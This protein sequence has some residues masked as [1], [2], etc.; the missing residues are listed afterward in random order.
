M[1]GML[2]IDDESAITE[3]LTYH[4]TQE[5]WEVAAA[6]SGESGIALAEKTVPAIIL[7]DMR[8]P[9]LDG[10]EVLKRLKA[11]QCTSSVIFM[12]G[13]GSIENAVA[14]IKLGAEH[15]VTKPVN[16]AEL[17]ALMNRTMET[18]KLRI[19]NL[20]YQ[21]RRGHPVVGASTEVLQLHHMI[22]LMAENANTTVLLLGE[23]GTGKELVAREIH[24][25]SARHE[26][27]FLD[28][29][30]AA[31]AE[32]LLESEMFGHERGAFTDARDCKQGLFEVADGGTVFLD[33]IGELPVS[34]Q[35]KLLRVLE[36]QTFKRVGGTRDIRVNVRIIA[37]TNE[38]L[39]RA[40]IEGR[41]RE[42]LY[43]RLKVFPVDLPPL[44]QRR[45]D[46]PILLSYF[47]SHYNGTLKKAV[48]GFTAE[49]LA[50]L[51]DYDW[52]GNVRELKNIVE[53]VIVLS[54]EDTINADMLPQEIT[55]REVYKPHKDQPASGKAATIKTLNEME[56]DYI[57][58]VLD[59]LQGNRSL[60]AK[61]L[62]IA[63]ST[64]LEKL[65]KYGLEEKT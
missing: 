49:A 28:I 40:I 18:R 65:K 9:D 24:R 13:W 45:A 7:L 33:E 46:I 47:V 15:Y 37:A 50:L 41:F 25:R 21:N 39:D 38:D 19:E 54:K 32:T 10:M 30:C 8:L 1:P 56:Q 11:L 3:A 59:S 26:R 35:P 5:G 62:G 51:R 34:V 6:Q 36:T 58:H 14:A 29:N 57:A 2:I 44:R 22:D 63:R 60:T 43:Y 52:P 4:F 12:T 53:R 64:L 48:N 17:S 23:S 55:G 27:P 61:T 31:I 20:Y 16:L 42:D